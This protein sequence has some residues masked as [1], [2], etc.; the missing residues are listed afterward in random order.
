MKKIIL[1]TLLL[2]FASLSISAQTLAPKSEGE[3]VE[4]KYYTLAYT[5]E[6]EQALWVHYH[7]TSE[8]LETSVKRKDNFRA[9]PSVTSG[10]ATLADY[11]KSGYDRGHL[12]P[13]ADMG[14]NAES[15]SESFFMS[16][17]SPQAP[18]FNR[19]GWK[20]LEEQVR[21]WAK[22]KGEIYVTTGP[23]F[24]DNIGSIGGNVTVP[25]YY[26]KVIYD[27]ATERAYAS[28]M[29]NTKIE[30]SLD[31]FTTT[32]DRVEELT[33]IDFLEELPD[34]LENRIE[35]QKVSMSSF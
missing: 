20:R 19:G 12:C 7:L 25:G 18:S 16:N 17:M 27:P 24:S 26:Y 33:G 22:Q 2:C 13:A 1:S 32:V 14:A 8:M 34:E 11:S 28:I 30:G 31:A 23:V 10:S 9:D 29:P 3:I 15:M 21:T 6:H 35:A 4:H 5:E